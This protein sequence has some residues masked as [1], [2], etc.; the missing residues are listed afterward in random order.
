VHQELLRILDDFRCSGA[1]M[2]T[3]QES[4]IYAVMRGEM[5]DR[6]KEY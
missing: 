1:R 5:G 4:K 2:V 3:E 6:E